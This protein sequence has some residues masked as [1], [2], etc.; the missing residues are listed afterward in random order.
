MFGCCCG[1][2]FF[3]DTGT[4]SSRVFGFVMFVNDSN[5]DK[6]NNWTTLYRK[7]RTTRSYNLSDGLHYSIC[8]WEIN[9]GTGA[10]TNT[11]NVYRWEGLNG[12]CTYP[13]EVNQT[14]FI[15][16]QS[17]QTL[18]KAR[19]DYIKGGNFIDPNINGFQES[20]LSDPFNP[21]QVIAEAYLATPFSASEEIVGV[22]G[23]T[24]EQRLTSKSYIDITGTTGNLPFRTCCDGGY[25]VLGAKVGQLAF[26]INREMIRGSAQKF[27]LADFG[28][29]GRTNIVCSTASDVNQNAAGIE[30]VPVWDVS[31][32]SDFSCG[33]SFS[34]PCSIRVQARAYAST[35]ASTT[36]DPLP[37]CCSFN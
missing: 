9:T 10:L 32:Y 6:M 4:L 29:V 13:Y 23:L 30:A 7:L 17:V 27:C 28:V 36:L 21:R 35:F 15:V 25:N 20:I 18:T 14:Q 2:K 19:N 37:A 5:F 34:G 12:I 26:N 11:Y 1:N 3:R 16:T 24:A 31:R 8:D 33:N 22:P